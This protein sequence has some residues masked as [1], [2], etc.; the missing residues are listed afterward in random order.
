MQHLIG[1][2]HSANRSPA[3]KTSPQRQT[4][5]DDQ[6]LLGNAALQDALN[7]QSA[8]APPQDAFAQW[9]DAAGGSILNQASMECDF[10]G[11]PN[12]EPT[13]SW[14]DYTGVQSPDTFIPPAEETS[15][16]V[17]HGRYIPA[18]DPREVFLENVRHIDQ[19]TAGGP[20][21]AGPHIRDGLI[22]DLGYERDADL[23]RRDARLWGAAYGLVEARC[24]VHTG[25]TNRHPEKEGKH[26]QEQW[27]E[28]LIAENPK[29]KEDTLKLRPSARD[30][31]R[32]Q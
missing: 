27:T 12:G 8:K 20:L 29:I 10:S 23:T 2:E 13:V 19:I 3:P 1:P 15:I 26:L 6:S 18:R 25:K 22:K 28:K 16:G 32:P 9:C 21:A 11:A 31:K 24:M 14:Q 4:V 17:R 5:A 7:Q 30:S